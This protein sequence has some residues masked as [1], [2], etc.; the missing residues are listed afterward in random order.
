MRPRTNEN[1]ETTTRLKV[2]FGKG[3]KVG[4]L[5]D[6]LPAGHERHGAHIE[7]RVSESVVALV[8]EAINDKLVVVD[9][10]AGTGELARLLG[11]LE[12]GDVPDVGHG[13]GVLP[14]VGDVDLIVL[15]VED[16]VCLPLGVEDPALVGV[17]DAF[18]GGLGDDLDVGLV[19]DVVARKS[20]SV[21]MKSEGTSRRCLHGQGVLVVAV[22]DIPAPVLEVRPTVDEALR[23]VHVTILT[24][25]TER[26]RI[27]GVSQ[28]KED[29]TST[30][31]AVTRQEARSNTVVFLL[32][33]SDVM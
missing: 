6:L 9:A 27:G 26:S 24:S 32:V 14:G 4:H 20:V 3:V 25:T 5:L 29:K 17:G 10:A 11:A 13:V 1:L 31:S 12:L 21:C 2:V 33:G 28:V 7:H 8:G 19:L 18:V 30:Q 15:V 22:A 23:I 16:E